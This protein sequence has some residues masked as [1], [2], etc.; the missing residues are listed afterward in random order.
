MSQWYAGCAL[1]AVSATGFQKRDFSEHVGDPN[2]RRR[3]RCVVRSGRRFPPAPLARGGAARTW[4][5]TMAG[6]GLD[7]RSRCE[8]VGTWY[9]SDECRIR[10]VFVCQT[11]TI[12]MRFRLA[13]RK[14]P[15]SF[16]SRLSFVR[17]TFGMHEGLRSVVRR[18]DAPDLTVWQHRT[19]ISLRLD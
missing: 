4:A 11:K 14:G 12:R 2:P 13:D 16:V 1:S 3:P 5:G 10:N 19:A 17:Q 18:S 15:F 6:R 8:I 7:L 9:P